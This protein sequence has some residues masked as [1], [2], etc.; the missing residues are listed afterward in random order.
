M[1]VVFVKI[2]GIWLN[3]VGYWILREFEF[4]CC[5]GYYIVDIEI[6][7]KG[8]FKYYNIRYNF[9]YKIIK[10]LGLDIVVDI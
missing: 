3:K 4:Y 8:Y 5:E 9:M 10:I 2:V 7:S 6:C 1:F